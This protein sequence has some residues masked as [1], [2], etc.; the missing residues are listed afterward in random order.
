MTT[1]LVPHR[2]ET[3]AKVAV[4][5]VSAPGSH[6][7]IFISVC[8][9]RTSKGLGNEGKERAMKGE[10]KMR[11]G[12]QVGEGAEW[13]FCAEHRRSPCILSSFKPTY[14]ICSCRL[15]DILVYVHSSE[16]THAKSI[17]GDK[18]KGGAGQCRKS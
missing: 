4:E 8:D 3:E 16:R 12:Q 17:I 2:H 18:E 9:W 13:P 14:T 10:R 15:V 11:R 1:P 6:C 7:L 5:V